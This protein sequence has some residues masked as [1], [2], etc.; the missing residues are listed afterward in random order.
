MFDKPILVTGLSRRSSAWNEK[1]A[2]TVLVCEFETADRRNL[3]VHFS[4]NAVEAL[5]IG[6][7]QLPGSLGPVPWLR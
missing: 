3:I 6:P 2:S 4:R 1:L 5:G 7:K